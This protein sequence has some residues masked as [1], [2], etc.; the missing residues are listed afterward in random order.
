MFVAPSDA[1]RGIASA[2][3]R[4]N[5]R[6]GC[7]LK[8]KDET[9]DRKRAEVTSARKTPMQGDVVASQR[10]HRSAALQRVPTETVA[11]EAQTCRRRVRASVAP[12]PSESS[13]QRGEERGLLGE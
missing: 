2:D 9:S 5:P 10:T 3:M 8:R 6:S 12:E 11:N 7:W 1:N 4:R 13:F